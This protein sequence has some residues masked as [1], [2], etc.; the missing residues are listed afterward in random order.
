M[1]T[2]QPG[3]VALLI[4]DSRI[5]IKYG[6]VI[7]SGV[8]DLQSTLRLESFS[9][10]TTPGFQKVAELWGETISSISLYYIG[11]IY[12]RRGFDHPE[13]VFAIVSKDG[14]CAQEPKTSVLEQYSQR[15]LAFVKGTLSTNNTEQDKM[16]KQLEAL[17]INFK[18]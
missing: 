6:G 10:P 1:N 14:V 9:L 7:Y 3:L 13:E 2:A 4:D 5:S 17:E 12:A 16:L 11:G 8:G 18:D 15:D